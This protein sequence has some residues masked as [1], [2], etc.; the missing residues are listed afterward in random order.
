MKTILKFTIVLVLMAS[1]NSE[2]KKG[3]KDALKAVEQTEEKSADK[4]SD[5][6]KITNELLKKTPLTDEELLAAFPIELMGYSLDKVNAIPYMQQVVGQF[7]GRKISLSVADAAGKNNSLVT[8]F[9][10]FYSYVP[11]SSESNKLIK[12]ERNGIKTISEFKDNE[13]EMRL[14]FDNR[15]YITLSAKALNP[16]ELWKA[17]DIHILRGYKD[18]N[19]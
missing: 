17:L 18:L 4:L 5:F 7:G 1:C 9:L 2:A 11:P 15:Y 6:D 8:T 12:I 14:L 3:T 19:K 10:G 13:T 16:E